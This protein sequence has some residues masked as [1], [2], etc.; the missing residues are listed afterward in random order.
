MFSQAT[1]LPVTYLGAW[2]SRMEATVTGK[3]GCWSLLPTL[4]REGSANS[5]SSYNNNNPIGDATTTYIS[6]LC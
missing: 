2:T 4:H 6:H 1:C 5:S 3:R